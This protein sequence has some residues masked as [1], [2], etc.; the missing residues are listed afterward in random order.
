MKRDT[1]RIHGLGIP[2]VVQVKNHIIFLA[3][4]TKYH[5]FSCA[6]GLGGDPKVPVSPPSAG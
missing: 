6:D 1:T 3:K 5:P 2:V 4:T